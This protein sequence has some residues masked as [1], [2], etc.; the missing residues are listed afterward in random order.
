[1]P[2]DDLIPYAMNSR[3]HSDAQIE[4]IMKSITAFG[5]TNPIL[6]WN[7]EIVGGH[8]RL[9]A[10]QRLMASG[11]QD[12][13]YLRSLPIVRLDRLTDAQRRAYVIADNQLA[14]LAGWDKEILPQELSALMGM[15]L[16]FDLECTGFTTEQ[17]AAMVAGEQEDEEEEGEGESNPFSSMTFSLHETQAPIVKHALELSAGLGGFDDAPNEN[18]RANALARI[19]QMFVN[20][21]SK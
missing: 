2:V 4:S 18:A 8:G 1:M 9:M 15:D 14:T 19:C 21:H 12:F 17:L 11:H 20:Q 5:F 3:T 6:I 10:A 13:A 16:G 7:N